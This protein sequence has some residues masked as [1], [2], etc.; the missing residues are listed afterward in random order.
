MLLALT[1]L[2]AIAVGVAVWLIWF[3][4]WAS[5]PAGPAPIQYDTPTQLAS[6]SVPGHPNSL[7]WSADD[8]YLAAG[9]WGTSPSNVFVVNVV[10]ASVATTVKVQGFVQALAF[11][12][13]G[14]W[15]AVAA[16]ESLSGGAAPAELV[17]F[18]VP[19]FTAKFKAKAGGPKNGF[20]DLAWAADSKALYATDDPG[21]SESKP[22]VRRWTL[23]AF[24]E[25]SAIRAPQTGQYGALAVSPDGRTLAVG[26]EPGTAAPLVIRLFDL[27][28]GA[29]RS[30]FQVDLPVD[31]LGFTP[32][33][34]A[35]GIIATQL[36]WWDVTTGR[37]AKPEPAR[38]K[39][40]PASLYR[41]PHHGD[42]LP[43][44]SPDA[45]MQALGYE[46]HSRLIGETLVEPANK[47]GAFVRVTKGA[48]GQTW[49]WR[50]GDS[51]GVSDSPAV[52]FSPDGTR[53]AG[54]INQGSGGSI[55]IW[56][57]PK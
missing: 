54:T 34:K 3:P 42:N 46:T 25:Q 47:Y 51:R 27:G 50:V 49:T 35:V 1:L 17:V 57:V 26:D 36:S 15:L 16:T 41:A 10:K 30:S 2:L 33:G 55:R 12:P 4:P 20:I 38:F 11:S 28:N 29:Q 19:A 56:A 45:S 44:V 5:I 37:P 6:V 43:A 7:A 48:T 32:D 24:A 21:D 9:T 31:R 18:D 53:L 8:A 13:N 39:V 52:A 23:P 40:P 14:K 22:S